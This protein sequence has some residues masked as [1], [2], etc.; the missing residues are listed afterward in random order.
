MGFAIQYMVDQ[1]SAYI[2]TIHPAPSFH[3]TQFEYMQTYQYL[4]DAL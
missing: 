4:E 2:N 1:F 3:H